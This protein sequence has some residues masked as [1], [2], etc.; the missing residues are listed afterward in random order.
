MYKK[1]TKPEIKLSFVS[2]RNSVRSIIKLDR[3]GDKYLDSSAQSKLRGIISEELCFK[4]FKFKFKIVEP[5]LEYLFGIMAEL[6]SEGIIM[7]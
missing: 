3:Y 6:P 7:V 2:V 4:L 5:L 1:I